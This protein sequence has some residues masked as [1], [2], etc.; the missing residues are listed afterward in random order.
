MIMIMTGKGIARIP[1]HCSNYAKI[2]FESIKYLSNNV[3]IEEVF[4]T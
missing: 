4:T 3:L 1:D 2:N